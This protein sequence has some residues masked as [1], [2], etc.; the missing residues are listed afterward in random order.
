MPD[1]ETRLWKQA[2]RR[3]PGCPD[4]RELERLLDEEART[5]D[6]EASRV[7]ARQCPHCA[8]E[9]E[10]MRQFAEAKAKPEEAADVA[11]I[12][13]QLSER[14]R[15]FLPPAAPEPQRDRRA[16]RSLFDWL[17]SAPGLSAAA[18]ATAVLILAIVAGP[19]RVQQPAPLVA[20]GATNLRSATIGGLKPIGDIG[21]LPDRFS[22]EPVQGADAY[23]LE[24]LEVDEN[25]I[26]SSRIDG[27]ETSIPQAV[28]DQVTPGRRLLWRVSAFD[29]EKRRLAA[30]PLVAFR[31]EVRDSGSR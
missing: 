11:W 25:V 23:R 30:S 19:W 5:P 27:T 8:A 1:N 29:S 9:L 4:V 10:L 17:L 2:L 24:I 28:R 18:L 26:W 15:E 31:V 6:L 14:R 16:K 20:P 21:S 7:H 3:D 22:W 12:G 13:Q